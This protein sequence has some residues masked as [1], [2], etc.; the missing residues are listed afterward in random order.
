M[1]LTPKQE[2]FCQAIVSG[3]SQADAYRTAY[4]ASKMTNKQI[5]EEASKLMASPKV[6]QRTQELRAPVVEKLQY[7]LE[8]AML[9]AQEAFE[10]SKSTQ[11]GG[12]MVA[13]VQL[14]AKLN[15]LLVER[16]EVRTGPL[17]GLEHDDLKELDDAIRIIAQARITQPGSI[18]STRH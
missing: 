4:A 3:M 5:W 16:K 1:A 15:G 11:S 2:A 6:S 14:R 12:A 13:A 9:E 10:V 8:Q 18:S 7:G 17:D